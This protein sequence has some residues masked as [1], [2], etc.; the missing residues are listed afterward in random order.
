[1]VLFAWFTDIILY[2]L[3]KISFFIIFVRFIQVNMNS[4]TILLLMNIYI[5]SIKNNGA[6]YILSIAPSVKCK[7]IVLYC[8]FAHGD[9]PEVK[10]LVHGV[11]LYQPHWK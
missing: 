6:K 11:Y 5:L 1:M 10:L 2:I 7:K 9:Y 3:K 8:L 4:Q